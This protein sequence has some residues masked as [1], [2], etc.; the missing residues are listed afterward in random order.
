MSKIAEGDDAEKINAPSLK[1]I[2]DLSKAYVPEKLSKE[3]EAEIRELY[4]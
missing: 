1:Q 3:F 4:E 2:L